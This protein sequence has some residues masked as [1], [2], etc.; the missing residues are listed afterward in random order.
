[1]TLSLSDLL[2]GASTDDVVATQIALAQAAGFPATSWQPG[3]VPRTFFELAGL[4]GADLTRLIAAIASGGFL[5]FAEDGWLDLLAQ[6]LYNLTRK[7][8]VYTQGGLI[9]TDESGIGGVVISDV[10]QVWVEAAGLRYRNVTTGTLVNG[11]TLQ[12]VWEAEF[13]GEAGNLPDGVA[14]EL[15]TSLPGVSVAQITDPGGWISQQGVDQESDPELRTRCRARWGELATG[16]T[17]LAYIFWALSSS[18]EITRAAVAEATGDGTVSVYV[19]GPSGDVS[20]EALAAANALIWSKRPQ[21][22]RPT[23]Y[24]ATEITY[25]LA[26]TIKIRSS[27]LEAAQ[28][29]V[30]AAVVAYFAAL[31]LGATIYRGPL[32]AA[33]LA[34]HPGVVNVALSNP[35]EVLLTAGQV[36]VPSLASP[37]LAWSAA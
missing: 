28:A 12:L 34:A 16:A 4:S 24:Q 6:Q 30:T 33:I 1:M 18:P 17:D 7:P 36:A 35:A 23:A 37:S 8:A 11:G 29:A 10:G 14:F 27:E 20:P 25:A 31:P 21:C 3:S 9:L 19:G 32:E 13:S 15:V 2:A 5:D 22:V 26:G